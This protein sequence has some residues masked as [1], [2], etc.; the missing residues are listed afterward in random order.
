[1]VQSWP[2]IQLCTL[3]TSVAATDIERARCKALQS[4]TNPCLGYYS[5]MCALVGGTPREDACSKQRFCKNPFTLFS[6]QCTKDSDCATSNIAKPPF[7]ANRLPVAD[8]GWK[9]QKPCCDSLKANI[10]QICVGV[11]DA[12]KEVMKP[13]NS[14]WPF[15]F[16]PHLDR[17]RACQFFVCLSGWVMGMGLGHV[18]WS[19]MWRGEWNSQQP[20]H[21]YHIK[22]NH[23]LGFALCKY[24]GIGPL[25]CIRKPL[26]S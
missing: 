26:T 20:H 10:E 3:D 11:T 15:A 17:V 7:D 1:M 2:K 23:F 12:V 14:P 6:Q 21:H 13:L 24:Q 22:P 4:T 19:V 18:G 25:P 8:L 16:I 5:N 9:M